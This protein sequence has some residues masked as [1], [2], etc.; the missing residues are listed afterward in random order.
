MNCCVLPEAIDGVVGVSAI[1]SSALGPMVKVALSLTLLEVAVI[2]VCPS[3]RL[4][5]KPLLY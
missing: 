3:T 1:V 4:W 2:T 5:A